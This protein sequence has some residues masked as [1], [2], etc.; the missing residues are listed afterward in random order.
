MQQRV[1]FRFPVELSVLSPRESVLSKMRGRYHR[2]CADNGD[3]LSMCVS[4]GQQR[5]ATGIVQCCNGSAATESVLVP[6]MGHAVRGSEAAMMGWE[7]LCRAMRSWG[8]SS[9]E[10]LSEWIGRE[11]FPQPSGE[12]ISAAEFRSK[13]CQEQRIRKAESQ[14][15]KDSVSSHIA[16]LPKRI[17]SRASAGYV[18]PTP[19]ESSSWDDVDGMCLDRVYTVV[20]GCCKVVLTIFVEGFDMHA[21][22]FWKACMKVFKQG[23]MSRKPG[24]GKCSVCCRSCCS[25]NRQGRAVWAKQSCAVV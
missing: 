17:A 10:D 14:C 7:A 24:R 16:R 9:R 2:F 6:W 5:V 19:F 22:K 25:A 3:R 4:C 1:Q 8:I 15:W 13:S 18:D 23:M 12:P 21:G 11:G 20:S